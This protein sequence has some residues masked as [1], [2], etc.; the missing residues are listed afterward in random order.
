MRHTGLRNI[1]LVGL[2]FVIASVL[3]PPVITPKRGPAVP[4]NSGIYA[5]AFSPDGKLGAFVQAGALTLVQMGS[6]EVRWRVGSQRGAIEALAFSQ[7]GSQVAT[8]TRAFRSWSPI[9]VPQ[10]PYLLVQPRL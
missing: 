4:A 9:G 7:D 10:D 1:A 3:V 8:C 2:Y 6:W 5:A